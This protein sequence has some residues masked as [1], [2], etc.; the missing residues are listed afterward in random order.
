MAWHVD[1]YI[2]DRSTANVICHCFKASLLSHWWCYKFLL[3]CKSFNMAFV[4]RELRRCIGEFF[5]R[6]MCCDTWPIIFPYLRCEGCEFQVIIDWKWLQIWSW[7]N[8]SKAIC[9]EV[10]IHIRALKWMVLDVFGFCTHVLSYHV[11][12]AFSWT[13]CR[14]MTSDSIETWTKYHDQMFYVPK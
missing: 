4:S 14:R 12:L 1:V 6:V 3:P 10:T 8:T 7:H 11:I 2:E 13:N 5:I 9:V